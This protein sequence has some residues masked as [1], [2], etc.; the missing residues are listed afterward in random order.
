M[1]LLGIYV[2]FTAKQ[3]PAGT[4]GVL[5]PGFFPILLGVLLIALSIIQ[6]VHTRHDKVEENEKTDPATIKRILISALIIIAYMVFINIL[7]F[8]IST[9]M[10]L[11]SIM[12]YFGVRKK[13]TLILTSLVTTAVLYFVFLKFLSVSLPTGIFF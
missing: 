1:I 3:F 5:G 13:S 12:F 10:F 4:N 7:G 9:P 2:I 11:F 8:L 6:I